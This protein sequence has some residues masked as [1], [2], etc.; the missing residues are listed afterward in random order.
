MNEFPFFLSCLVLFFLL[1]IF[2]IFLIFYFNVFTLLFMSVGLFFFF[3]NFFSLSCRQ[4]I[5]RPL[6]ALIHR[7]TL[8]VSLSICLL[9]L[10]NKSELLVRLLLT[11]VVVKH[12]V[13]VRS[14]PVYIRRTH[15]KKKQQ[16]NP[17]SESGEKKENSKKKVSGC[18]KRS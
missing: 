4:M 12:R 11:A 6:P 5:Y 7:E 9:F 16:Q 10:E 14:C 15:T 18:A 3:P 13:S 2:N 17:N 1:P 8:S